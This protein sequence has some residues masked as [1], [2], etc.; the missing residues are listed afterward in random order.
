[1]HKTRSVPVRAELSAEPG[2]TRIPQGGSARGRPLR[3][4]TVGAAL[5]ARSAPSAAPP[6]GRTPITLA[7]A[8]DIPESP[9]FAKSQ[10]LTTKLGTRPRPLASAHA[11]PPSELFSDDVREPI[12]L[13]AIEHLPPRGGDHGHPERGQSVASGRIPSDATRPRMDKVAVVL[14][15]QSG[16]GPKHIAHVIPV[17]GRFAAA[18]I[19]VD[20]MVQKGH[21]QAVPSE[22]R[23]KAQQQDDDRLHRRARVVAHV[24]KRSTKRPRTLRTLHDPGEP[25]QLRAGDQGIAIDESARIIRVKTVTA[26]EFKTEL[27]KTGQG[28]LPR[29]VQKTESGTLHEQSIRRFKHEARCRTH[30][31]RMADH[32]LKQ[33]A[34][35][36]VTHQQMNGAFEKTAARMPQ[37]PD[38]L[39]AGNKRRQPSPLKRGK[40]QRRR[41]R[42]AQVGNSGSMAQA[43]RHRSEEA[44]RIRRKEPV[45]RCALPISA[46]FSSWINRMVS[47]PSLTVLHSFDN[48]MLELLFLLQKSHTSPA[49]T[50]RGF[51]RSS[52]KSNAVPMPIQRG[53]STPNERIENSRQTSE[54]LAAT[55]REYPQRPLSNRFLKGRALPDKPGL[56]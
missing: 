15:V 18:A 32:A 36:S 27:G 10:K 30:R 5:S 47:I 33:T 43:E 48:N 35:R 44:T 55:L 24:G 29:S 21:R 20:P 3:Q 16:L 54:C 26:A 37:P 56:T 11:Q 17:R 53:S 22:A 7:P 19:D 50:Q 42:L 6:V 49:P 52:A 4:T 51:S 8:P 45:G 38:L 12:H 13:I 34:L 46:P 25:D 31:S 40:P 23:R 14:H 41:P 2:L 1:M 28:Q 9:P 39:R